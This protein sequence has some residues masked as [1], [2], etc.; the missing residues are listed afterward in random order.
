MRRTSVVTSGFLTLLTTVA[1]AQDAPRPHRSA[2]ELFYEAVPAA[3]KPAPKPSPGTKPPPTVGVQYRPPVLKYSIVRLLPGRKVET[4]PDFVFHGGDKIQIN[5]Q[6]N[7]PGYLYVVGK[8]P[9]GAWKPLF[10]SPEIAHGDN[11]VDTWHTY[12]LPSP[13]HQMTMV[14][15]AGTENVFIVFSRQA[16]PDLEQLIY[17]L[18]RRPGQPPGQPQG[19]PDSPT[20]PKQMIE[21]AN[22]S[23]D[24]ATVNRLRSASSRDLIVEKVDP[25][26][27]IDPGAKGEKK[28][29]AVY[30]V[31][32]AGTADSRLV[33]DLHLVHQ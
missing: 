11:R 23:I 25:D 5:V 30:V 17:S 27:P 13:E 18:G 14:D 31:N 24:D 2:R 28:E 20:A 6:T 32:P 33:A 7:S 15:P 19:Q 8:G 4:S 1:L 10:P 9:S 29:T 3:P 26:T 21:A 22:L 12:T 16:V